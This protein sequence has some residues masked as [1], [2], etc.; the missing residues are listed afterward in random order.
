MAHLTGFVVGALL[1]ATAALP[2]LHGSCERVP[3]WLRGRWRG[4]RQPRRRLGLCV[5]ELGSL[6]A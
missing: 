1:G 3:Q 6:D 5:A 2:R 4:A